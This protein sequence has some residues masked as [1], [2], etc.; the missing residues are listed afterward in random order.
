MSGFE[1]GVLVSAITLGSLIV[2]YAVDPGFRSNTRS[3]TYTEL[4]RENESLR[5]A[6]RTL[7]DEIRN[8]KNQ[9]Q[10][11]ESDRQHLEISIA[12]LRGEM[13]RSR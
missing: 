4:K 13:G 1:I 3:P 10:I 8:L 6:Q 7:V 12:A 2:R 5:V 11:V 9:L